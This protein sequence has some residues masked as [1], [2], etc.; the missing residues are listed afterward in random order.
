MITVEGKPGTIDVR[1][2]AKRLLVTVVLISTACGGAEER[3][4]GVEVEGVE[5][6]DAVTLVVDGDA[7]EDVLEGILWEERE[8]LVDTES[9]AGEHPVRSLEQVVLLSGSDALVVGDPIEHRL[10]RVSGDGE[11]TLL[12]GGEGDGP[13]EFRSIGWVG[14]AIDGGV[15]VWDPQRARMTE[16]DHA[17]EMR[18]EDQ[19]GPVLAQLGGTPVGGISDEVVLFRRRG[20]EQPDWEPG[21]S[22]HP[23]DDLYLWLWGDRDASK[24]GR[25]SRSKVE[26]V[27]AQGVRI[28]ATRLLGDDGVIALGTRG[29]LVAV[30]RGAA[31]ISLIDLEDDVQRNVDLD[32]IEPPEITAIDVTLAREARIDGVA[33]EVARAG[34]TE[35]AE[36][37]SAAGVLPPLD[38]VVMGRSENSIFLSESLLPSEEL[39]SEADR[40]W[41]EIIPAGPDLVACLRLPASQHLVGVAGDYAFAVSQDDLGLERLYRV[42]LR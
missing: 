37:V 11:R 22:Y 41:F 19:V 23:W 33:G 12:V 36:R 38:T 4:A 42:P 17:G 29:G 10:W 28:A 14:V 3:K 30:D 15:A 39:E 35:V 8:L 40:L 34:R 31:R 9:D 26:V 2:N 7:C 5:T 24:V 6:E 27:V 32:G 21:A 18:R 13:R 16:W 20:S 1:G 25:V